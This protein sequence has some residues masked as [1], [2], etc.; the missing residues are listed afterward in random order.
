MERMCDDV[1]W[2]QFED[3]E[4]RNFIYDEENQDD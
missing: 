1:I 3:I 4:S 2:K